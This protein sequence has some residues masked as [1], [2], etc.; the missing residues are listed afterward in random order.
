MTIGVESLKYTY[1]ENQKVKL[2]LSYSETDSKNVI[3]FVHGYPDTH[4]TWDLQVNVLKEKFTLGAIDLR[5]SGRSSKPSLQNNL[6]III[7]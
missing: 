1:L 6:N 3:L 4:K 5:G 2:F 7:R